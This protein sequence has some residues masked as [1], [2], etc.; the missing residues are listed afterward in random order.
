M[1]FLPVAAAP[2][3]PAPAPAAAPMAA[4]L[5]P[6]ANAPMTA[7]PAAPPPIN[8]AS[9][10]PLP[11]SL[12]PAELVAKVYSLPFTVTVRRC[13]YSFAGVESRP[14]ACTALTD[15]LTGEPFGITTLPPTVTSLATDP[16]T[17]WP[18]FAV[19]ELTVW[20]VTTEMAVPL[21][22]VP[23]AIDKAGTR[24]TTARKMANARIRE[25]IS[26]TSNLKLGL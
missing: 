10:L 6:P 2:A 12:L 17:G 1:S 18:T 9:R 19:L 20:S 5:P 15:N 3:V 8:P 25:F 22:T 24:N 13:R 23:P 14:E 11:F 26:V 21:G 4:P 7:P 16:V